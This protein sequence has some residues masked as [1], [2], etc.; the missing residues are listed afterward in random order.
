MGSEVCRDPLSEF[1]AAQVVK[2]AASSSR[3]GLD[4]VMPLSEYLPGKNRR[5]QLTGSSGRC[6]TVWTVFSAKRSADVYVCPRMSGGAVKVSL[7]ASGSWQVGLTAE[8][9]KGRT[10]TQSR[11]WEIWQRG[12]G[13]GP[14]VTRAWYLLIPDRELRVGATDPK[15]F[16]LP[17][18]GQGY[19]A[20]VELLLTRNDGPTVTIDDAHVVG[21]WRL[22]K[23]DESCLV[24]ARRVPWTSELQSWA[25]SARTQV[26]AQSAAAGVPKSQE[27]R[28]F[29]HGHDAQGVRFGIE[30]APSP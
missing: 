7:H 11:H 27:H 20:S 4:S 8:P 21:R 5:I 1:A 16:K 30:L 14:G 10:P 2:S 22:E 25:D 6:S 9:A 17:A 26:A 19:A 24:V 12:D 29:S 15:A 23:H 28:Y 13:I 18:V 3:K